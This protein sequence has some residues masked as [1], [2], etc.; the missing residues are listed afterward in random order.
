VIAGYK[1]YFSLTLTEKIRGQEGEKGEERNPGLKTDSGSPGSCGKCSGQFIGF[2]VEFL[3]RTP[4]K[5][6]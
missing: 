6:A 4:C 3:E 2:R 5:S 1:G